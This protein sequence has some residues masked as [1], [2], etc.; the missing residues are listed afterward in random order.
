M[1]TA[2]YGNPKENLCGA[3]FEDVFRFCFGLNLSWLLAGVDE[4]TSMRD[5]V[6]ARCHKL[7]INWLG[8]IDMHFSSLRFI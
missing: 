1:F 4:T 8:L 2:M 5:H 3:L 7:W 6:V